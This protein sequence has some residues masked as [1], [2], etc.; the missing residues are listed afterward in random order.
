MK[1]YIGISE[2]RTNF[3]NYPAWFT[4]EDLGDDIELIILSFL[5]NNTD[6]I[7]KCDGFVLT[8]GVDIQPSYYGGAV[9]YENQPPEFQ[10]ARDAFEKKIYEYAKE[11]QLPVLGICRGMQLVNVLEGGSLIQDLGVE[12]NERHKAAPEDKQHSVNIA[13][14]SLLHDIAGK[15]NGQVNSAHHQAIDENTISK[16]LLPNAWSADDPS[17]IEGLEYKDKAGKPFLLCVQWHPERIPGKEQN[18]LSQ[19]I[20]EQFIAAVKNLKR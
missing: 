5:K 9:N 17:I 16:Q 15:T 8:G 18:P 13:P 19:N 1:K 3:A 7:S 20:K 2:T 12:G 6:D 11:N 14:G 10:P 4:K